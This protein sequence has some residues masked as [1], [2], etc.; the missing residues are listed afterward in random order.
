[1]KIF[2]FLTCL[3]FA[4]F[5]FSQNSYYFTNPVL[6]MFTTTTVDAQYYGTYTDDRTSLNYEFTSEGVFV[7]SISISSISKKSVRETSTYSVRNG[8]IFGVVKDDS[9]PCI[10]E[11]GY[12]YFG[13]KSKEALA[14]KHILSRIDASHYLINY[15]DGNTYTPS[16]VTFSNKGMTIQD[17]DYDIESDEFTYIAQRSSIPKGKQHVILLSPTD[18]ETKVFLEKKPFGN[19]TNFVKKDT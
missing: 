4:G 3:L 5:A 18:E 16:L 11:N 14:P 17:F 10:L 12:Y 9:I 6:S 7:V 8:L 13:I 19:A 2:S 15:K 1:M